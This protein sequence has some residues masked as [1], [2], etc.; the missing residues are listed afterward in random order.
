MTEVEYTYGYYTELNP[1]RTRLALLNAGYAYPEVHTACELGFGQGLSV[2]IHGAASNAEWFGT[3]FNPTQANFAKDLSG[4]PERAARLFDE[5]FDAFCS[6]VD[7]PDFDFIGLHG[8]WSWVSD[9]NRAVIADFIKRK[10]KVGGVLYIS[11]NTQPGWAALAP[12]RD[13]LTGFCDAL[14]ASGLHTAQRIGA[15]LD[16][17]EK[18]LDSGA[19]YGKANPTVAVQLKRL[20]SQPTNYLAH[21]YFNRDW[22]PMAFSR[23]G[24]WMESLK[25]QFAGSAHYLDQINGINLSADQARLLEEIPDWRFRESVKDFMVNQR[26]RR[27][28]WIK[29]GRRLSPFERTDRLRVQRVILVTP[30]DQVKLQANGPLGSATLKEEIYCPIL[31]VLT[32]HQPHSLSDIEKAV[33]GKGLQLAHV[34]EAIMV[35]AGNGNIYSVQDDEVIRKAKPA[36]DAFNARLYE[37]ARYSADIAYLASPV[38]GGALSANRFEQL[39]LLA[40]RS[41]M[42]QPSEWTRY[43]ADLMVA[44]NQRIVKDGKPIESAAEQFEEIGNRAAEFA[45]VREPIFRALGIE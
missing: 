32:D 45:R 42:K 4:S 38:T 40:R 2:N 39:A 28:Y 12:M 7:L 31:D 16:F 26:F 30:P 33:A 13:L 19:L 9:A 27:D 35:L 34:V 44:Q 11:Y 5:S 18:V 21:E 36:T 22:V 1:L 20:R 29:G 10:L 14:A 6:R 8:I 24:D 43:I 37:K 3:D 41:G 25:L 15:S 17:A 23:M